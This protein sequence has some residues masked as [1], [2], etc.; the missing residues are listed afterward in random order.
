MW[1]VYEL[2]D[3]RTEAVFYVGKGSG[4]RMYAHVADA[5]A[6]IQSSKC[7]L[8]RDIEACGLE[9]RHSVA[10]EFAVEAHAYAFEKKRIAKIGLHNLT[11]IAA[12][13]GTPRAQADAG[14][15]T[16]EEAAVILS[17]YILRATKGSMTAFMRFGGER[18]DISDRLLVLVTKVH[19]LGS[20]K[21]WNWVNKF[22]LP[23]GV[24]FSG[25]EV[26]DGAS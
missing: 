16:R 18:I 17:A 11:N 14:S 19:E 10:K 26:V 1:Y 22:S 4:R 2:I 23:I 9:V 12:G 8:I 13:G 5:R 3:P 20:T 6:G 21:G 7:D 24:N 25:T 15:R